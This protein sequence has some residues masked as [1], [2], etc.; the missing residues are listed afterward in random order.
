[1][2][3]KSQASNIVEVKT[4]LADKYV[5]L[6]RKRSS[7]PARATLLR[8]AERFRSQAENARKGMAK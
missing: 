4:A 3:K 5:R 1:M 8:H 7:K 2:S 6:A